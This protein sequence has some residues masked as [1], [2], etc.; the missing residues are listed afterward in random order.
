LRRAFGGTGA[1]RGPAAARPDLPCKSWA[2]GHTRSGR[3][4]E[5]IEVVPG[6]SYRLEAFC[7]TRNIG[8]VAASVGAAV[9][10]LD[11]SGKP[12]DGTGNTTGAPDDALPLVPPTRTAGR[13]GNGS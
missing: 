2:S 5:P 7:R 11:A 12:H 8:D 13:A 9:R 4:G 10:W 1:R 3:G 6:R